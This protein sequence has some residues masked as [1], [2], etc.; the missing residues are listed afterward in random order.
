[1]SPHQVRLLSYLWFIVVVVVPGRQLAFTI[2]PTNCYY[3]M[4]IPYKVLRKS[5]EFYDI[6]TGHLLLKIRLR[7]TSAR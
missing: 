6:L 3:K 5:L 4:P 1:M 7:I 2:R